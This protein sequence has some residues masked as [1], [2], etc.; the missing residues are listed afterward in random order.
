MRPLS[1]FL[2][3]GLCLVTGFACSRAQPPTGRWEGTYESARTMIAAR[4]QIDKDGTITISAPDAFDVK[5]NAPGAREVIR[6]KLAMDLA[7]HWDAVAPMRFD[8]DGKIFRKPGGIAPQLEWD[9]GTRQMTMFVYPG[10]EATIRVPL[11]AVKKFSPDP[12][13]G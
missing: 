1:A 12:W 13:P 7:E 11:H 10:R 2:V 5:A 8:F 9:A 6:Q 4:L 3:I